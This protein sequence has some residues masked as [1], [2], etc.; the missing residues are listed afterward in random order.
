MVLGYTE[1]CNVFFFLSSKESTKRKTNNNIDN[2]EK[3]VINNRL[4]ACT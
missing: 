2:V 4:N 1:R 3:W